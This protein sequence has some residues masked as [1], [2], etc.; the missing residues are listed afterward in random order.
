MAHT[1]SP[2]ALRPYFAWRRD[3]LVALAAFVAVILLGVLDG[4]LL[5]IAVSIAM[6]LKRFAEPRVSWL[7]QLPHSRDYVDTARHP[8]AASVPNVLIARPEAPLFFGNADAIFAAIRARIEAQRGAGLRAVVLS[9]EESPDLDG[10]SVEA[11]ADFAAQMRQWNLPLVLARTKDAVRELLARV[12][13]A[14]LPASAYAAW[15]VDDAVAALNDAGESE[16]A[17]AG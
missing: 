3:R 15:S 1:L 13:M 5:A 8:E 16:T 11:L 12:D 10:T 14:A 4:L 17:S 9:M 2:A 6:L 7:G